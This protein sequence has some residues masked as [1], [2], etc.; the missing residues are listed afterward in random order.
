MVANRGRQLVGDTTTRL[1]AAKSVDYSTGAKVAEQ[2][3][4][5]IKTRLDLVLK[6]GGVVR[7]IFEWLRVP[8]QTDIKVVN[9][10]SLQAF[11][12]SVEQLLAVGGAA[13]A[14]GPEPCEDNIDE[15]SETAAVSPPAVLQAVA[16]AS[17]AMDVPPQL[18]PEE[19]AIEPLPEQQDNLFETAKAEDSMPTP[20]AK[21]TRLDIRS[22]FH[23][24]VHP[25]CL[26]DV[27][28]SAIKLCG[29]SMHSKTVR[30]SL[31]DRTHC[32]IEQRWMTV[33]KTLGPKIAPTGEDK[34]GRHDVVKHMGSYWRVVAAFGKYYGRWA[35]VGE[36][37]PLSASHKLFLHALT[38]N[39]TEHPY[40][41]DN[42]EAAPFLV[43]AGGDTCQDMQ[44]G[45]VPE[46]EYKYKKMKR[47]A[48]DLWD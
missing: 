32:S 46:T 23:A 19:Y 35:C 16:M 1:H 22:A 3:W 7:K 20:A 21:A 39:K 38:V 40:V 10:E 24:F 31:P 45:L 13:G 25:K 48:D 14:A 18:G 47:K 42:F 17:L 6:P 5:F 44:Y 4:P 26:H 41:K 30:A 11:A 43:A 28:E 29:H 36:A 37:V 2:L 33:D 12:D 15:D 27:V 9:T 8:G 34:V